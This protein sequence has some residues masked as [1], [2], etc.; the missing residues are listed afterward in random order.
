[1]TS[2]S[3]LEVQQLHDKRERQARIML[4]AI[5]VPVLAF[6]G[7]MAWL[8]VAAIGWLQRPAPTCP[9]PLTPPAIIAPV[10]YPPQIETIRLAPGTPDQ[11]AAAALALVRGEAARLKRARQ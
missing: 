1:M 8:I 11:Q 7:L 9:G 4:G 3:R 2:S 6:L 10:S 5:A